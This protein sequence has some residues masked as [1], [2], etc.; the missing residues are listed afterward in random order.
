[1]ELRY[2]S[3]L[4]SINLDTSL[5][6][7]RVPTICKNITLRRIHMG[8]FIQLFYVGPFHITNKYADLT[9]SRSLQWG[10]RHPNHSRQWW[11]IIYTMQFNDRS[12]WLCHG[13]I[14]RNYTARCFLV[15]FVETPDVPNIHRHYQFWNCGRL[16]HTVLLCILTNSTTSIITNI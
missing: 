16:F 10:S 6:T 15:A 5:Y 12:F 8:I 1:M 3:Y 11:P 7:T 14:K 13:L 4:Q 9:A 2:K